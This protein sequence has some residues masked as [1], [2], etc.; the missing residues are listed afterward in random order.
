[1]EK[2]PIDENLVQLQGQT[3]TLTEKI[4]ELTIPRTGRSQFCWTGCC[5][6]GHLVNEVIQMRGM[7][8][9]QNL[10]GPSPRP[11]RGVS[12]VSLNLPFHTPTPY[13]A[14]LGNQAASSI[15]Y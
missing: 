7:G 14:F 10:M 15:E 12:K 2:P 11:T 1:V 4:Q 5:K 13:H 3:S 8:P 6:E 9:P